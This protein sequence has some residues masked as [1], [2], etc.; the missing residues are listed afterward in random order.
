MRCLWLLLL[1]LSGS[2]KE[3]LSL[4]LI[5]LHCEGRI[6]WVSYPTI[7]E[8]WSCL[9]LLLGKGSVSCPMWTLA[10]FP[11]FIYFFNDYLFLVS[12]GLHWCSWALSSCSE[13]GLLFLAIHGLLIVVASLAT[14]HRL[15]APVSAVVV[16]RPSF[17]S[18]CG[19]FQN[20]GSNLSPCNGRW[21]PIYYTTRE[22]LFCLF[23]MV[24]S[25]GSAGKESTCNMGD[26]GSI[27]E[28][29]R[30]PGEGKG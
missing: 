1:W 4:G 18:A 2:T 5:I 25:C 16:Y 8:L 30:S 23:L 3:V 26:L 22:V 15:K 24:L 9:V 19:I 13:Q 10:L 14:E 6:F 28:L 11:L 17:S 7:H 20:Y 27:P 29:G 12:L 21:I